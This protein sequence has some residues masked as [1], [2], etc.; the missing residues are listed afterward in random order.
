[1]LGLI[2]SAA[3]SLKVV[4]YIFAVDE[5]AARVR[6][7]LIEAARRRDDVRVIVDGFGAVAD[8]AFF[9][10]LIEAGGT[11]SCFLPKLTRGY[12]IRN[13]QKLVVVDS[14]LAMLGGFNVENAI[15]AART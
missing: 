15:R 13:H 2:G 7:A 8:G 11:F 3:T 10:P 9:A 5:S 1:M 6:D 4:F 12:L 14:K